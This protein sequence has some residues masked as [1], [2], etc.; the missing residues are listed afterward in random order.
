MLRNV[1]DGALTFANLNGTNKP[2]EL[3]TNLNMSEPAIFLNRKFP[4]VS[5]I[6]ATETNGAAM[7]AVKALTGDGLFSGHISKTSKSD[8]LREL[9][10]DL[11]EDADE[12]RRGGQ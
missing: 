8:G 5:M 9:L 2:D 1:T 6:R 4:I 11:A 10:L 7:G 12:A 3:Q